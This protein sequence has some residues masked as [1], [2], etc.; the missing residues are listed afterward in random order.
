MGIGALI[1]ST[2]IGAGATIIGSNKAASATT[3]AANTAA[4]TQRAALAQQE[5]ETAPFRAGGVA[6]L[7]QLEGLLGLPNT[8]QG[9]GPAALGQVGS[10][11]QPAGAG[12]PGA[13]DPLATL[14]ATPGYQF[15]LGEGLKATANAS[16]LSGGGI[17]GNTLEA[18]TKYASGL[19]EGTWGA[20]VTANQ[21]LVNTGANAATNTASNIGN[22]A[23]NLSNIATNQGTN[24]ANIT[25]GGIGGVTGTLNNALNQY[26]Q[27]QTLAS[28]LNSTQNPG[29]SPTLS[30][31]P[32]LPTIGGTPEFP[33]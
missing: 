6:A 5:A 28:I 20:Q 33:G 1:A 15:T 30:P 23:T 2:V 18:L 22:T 21:N 13:A 27:Q 32:A 10:L 19:A 11:G 31:V 7:G 4:D 25:L 12:M 14:R 24:L 29:V 17:G 26:T 8:T 9:T 16:T 3:S